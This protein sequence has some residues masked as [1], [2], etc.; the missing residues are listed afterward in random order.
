M[1]SDFSYPVRY[2]YISPLDC[3]YGKK[4]IKKYSQKHFKTLKLGNSNNCSNSRDQGDKL[5]K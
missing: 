2:L 4:R 3:V 1:N 5:I